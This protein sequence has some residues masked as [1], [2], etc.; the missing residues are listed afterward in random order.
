MAYAPPVTQ[1]AARK[2]AESIEAFWRDGG[3]P[4]V[5][6]WVEAQSIG[7]DGKVFCV[8]SNLVNGLPPSDRP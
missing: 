1:K 6:A 7:K 3:Y 4:Q 5:R 8:R 2:Q